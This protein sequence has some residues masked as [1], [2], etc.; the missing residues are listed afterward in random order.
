MRKEKKKKRK[1][2]KGTNKHTKAQRRGPRPKSPK[3][4][5][6]FAS[7]DRGLEAREGAQAHDLHARDAV[8]HWESSSGGRASDRCATRGI[9]AVRPSEVRETPHGWLH[10]QHHCCSI[11]IAIIRALCLFSSN[12]NTTM[13]YRSK[14]RRWT[15]VRWGRRNESGLLG[16]NVETR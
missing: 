10:H 4:P 13:E 9:W 3:M 14:G 6:F 2:K 11:V 16:R 1:E 7:S 12:F 8:S 15:L 5:L